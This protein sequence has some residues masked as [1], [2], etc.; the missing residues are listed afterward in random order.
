MGARAGLRARP[1]VP[2]SGDHTVWD[3]YIRLRPRGTTADKSA[4]HPGPPSL[5]LRRGEPRRS[6]RLPADL[7][8]VALAKPEAFGAGGFVDAAAKSPTLQ[9][10]PPER[11]RSSR[12]GGSHGDGAAIVKKPVAVYIEKR[13]EE[14]NLAA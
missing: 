4:A 3:S 8:G 1:V 14:G 10:R 2:R 13:Y 7:S 5:K 9:A 12:E 6:T 11:L